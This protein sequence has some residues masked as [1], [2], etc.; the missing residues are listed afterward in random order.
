M[1]HFHSI[2]STQFIELY[3][4]CILQGVKIGVGGCV[5]FLHFVFLDIISASFRLLCDLQEKGVCATRMNN[6]IKIEMQKRKGER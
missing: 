1:H 2:I 6:L 3:P 5:V 4:S